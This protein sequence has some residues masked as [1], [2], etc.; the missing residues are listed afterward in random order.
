[1]VH[2]PLCKLADE[3]TPHCMHGECDTGSKTCKCDANW[4]GS[5]DCS[6]CTE[7]WTGTDCKTPVK[8]ETGTS[9]FVKFLTIMAILLGVFACMGT[10]GWIGWY[11]YKKYNVRL[12]PFIGTTLSH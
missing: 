12:Q 2:Y 10:V 5:A 8:P 7:G 3:C 11:Q 6:K 9:G 4:K 1:M